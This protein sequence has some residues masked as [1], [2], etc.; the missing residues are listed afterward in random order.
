MIDCKRILSIVYQ[1]K[2]NKHIYLYI[3]LRKN[4]NNLAV[5]V[6]IIMFVVHVFL[7]MEKKYNIDA[8]DR[9]SVVFGKTF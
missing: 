1:L 4:Q 2:Y 8:F 3:W 5:L 9:E 6:G 7:K